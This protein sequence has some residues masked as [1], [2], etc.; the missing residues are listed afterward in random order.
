MD[1][2]AASTEPPSR[3]ARALAV[4]GA[5][6][7]LAPCLGL[8]ASPGA[9]PLGVLA[10][11]VAIVVGL[12][13][14]GHLAAAVIG[15]RDP[16]SAL[17]VVWGLALYVA[18][19]G[20]LLA[21]RCLVPEVCIGLLCGG[22]VL[23]AGRA[24]RWLP[25]WRPPRTVDLGGAVAAAIA[26]GIVALQVLAAAGHWSGPW[27]DAETD[28][29]AQ[30]ARLGDTGALADRVGFAREV[31][32]GGQL[33]I[34]ALVSP[35]DVRTAQLVDDGILFAVFV[36]LAIHHV[37]RAGRASVIVAALAPLALTALPT[38]LD[39]VA[40]RW[41]VVV[42]LVGTAAT[43][44]RA[45]ER[46][47]RGLLVMA[48]AVAFAAATVRH[49]L[50]LV[51]A[52]MTWEA[53]RLADTW[54]CR[55]WWA[56]RAAVAAVVVLVPFV[57]AAA[58]ADTG[59][60]AGLGPAVHLARL[61]VGAAAA[62]V[63]Y[64]LAA[65]VVPAVGTAALTLRGCLAGII[66]C[67]AFAPT[68]RAL[69][70]DVA[71][72]VVALVTVL[73]IDLLAA[74]PTVELPPRRGRPLGAV[75]IVTTALLGIY[76]LARFAPGYPVA[77]WGAKL[78]DQ[79]DDARAL[80]ELAPRD[81]SAQAAAYRG[82]QAVIPTGAT[83]G[84]W[85]VRPDLVDYARHAVVDLRAPAARRG[86]LVARALDYVIVDAAARPPTTGPLADTLRAS[87]ARYDL[88]G[89]VVYQLGR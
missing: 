89:V 18:V 43:L 50:V 40:P 27:T 41:T 76:A 48:I 64:A 66:G 87:A 77:S 26:L 78:R 46:G 14:L 19:A 62:I 35:L 57:A 74:P 79:V 23:S 29:L 42:L 28:Q 13:G 67:A 39:G 8:V 75:V 85:L 86:Q 4:L 37:R 53:A 59:A 33:V 83:V 45:R 81:R 52:V 60:V 6:A 38:Y 25:R 73:V 20:V 12:H 34:A 61:G 70:Q 68:S 63:L 3:R 22:C 7:A 84:V 5:V 55:G 15:D 88:S 69:V 11:A 72:L 65:P 44:E 51:A 21:A 80:G 71:P 30:L 1:T 58:L 32:L 31:G 16:P 2:A 49:G 24:S 36:A 82:A 54:G 10:V 47:S 17:A 56:R 9:S